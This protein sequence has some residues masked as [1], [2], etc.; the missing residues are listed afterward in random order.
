[1]STNQDDLVRAL[2]APL[3]DDQVLENDAFD[4]VDDEVWLLLR[5]RYEV[6]EGDVVAQAGEALVQKGDALVEGRRAGV[7]P[8]ADPGGEELDV[9]AQG[10]RQ[11]PLVVAGRRQGTNV[12]D[13]WHA[14]ECARARHEDHR[15]RHQG[16]KAD[17]PSTCAHRDFTQRGN[18]TA[19][20]L[21]RVA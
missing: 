9:G 18:D 14:H 1:M 2:H 17:G 3:L 4:A 19:A 12:G 20:S 13:A 16:D 10:L 8:F 21:S 6:L 15:Q 11:R 5:Y 7:V